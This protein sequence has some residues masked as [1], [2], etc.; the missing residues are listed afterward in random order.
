MPYYEYT[1]DTTVE[2]YV[3][4]SPRRLAVT[5]GLR[6]KVAIAGEYVYITDKEGRPQQTIGVMQYRI[7]AP[8]P[9]KSAA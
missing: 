7:P 3:V 9:K 8:R 1:L 6:V 5:E 4:K 2:R